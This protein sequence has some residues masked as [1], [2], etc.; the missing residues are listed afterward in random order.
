MTST[1]SALRLGIALV[2]VLLLGAACASDGGSDAG[3]GAGSTG[4]SATG[5]TGGGGT[6]TT[7]T[8]GAYGSGGG[9]RYDYGSDDNGGGK[10][11]SGTDDS[12]GGGH[13]GGDVALTADNYAFSPTSLE[14]ASGS[15][16]NVENANSGTPH[17]FTVDG[18]D[19]DLELSPGDVE[20]VE[21][22][23]DPGTYSFHCRFHA[24]MTGTLT[25]R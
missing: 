10:D 17:T 15:E 9:G 16:I 20:D 14:V 5:S 18:T 7:S 22:D 11:D 19:V 13:A 6:G 3:A 21:I 8:G 25:V 1:R 24:A 23:L 4:V 12:A 2:A